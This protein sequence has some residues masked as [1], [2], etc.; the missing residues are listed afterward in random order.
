MSE[1]KNNEITRVFNLLPSS[2]SS[3]D[4]YYSNIMQLKTNIPKRYSLEQYCGPIKDQ[5]DAGF[6]HSFAGSSL[7]DIQ[8]NIETGFKYELSP[9]FLAKQVKSIDN[10]PSTE[11]AQLIYVCKA[12]QQ[13]GIIKEAYYPYSQYISGSLQFPELKYTKVPKYKI[14][15]YARCDT[16]D[17]MKQALSENK[18]ILLGITCCGNIRDLNNNADKFVP[19]PQGFFLG[20][21][22]LVIVGYDDD[23]THTYK[24]GRTCKGFFRIQNSW[25]TDWGDQGFAWLPYDYLTYKAHVIDENYITFFTEAWTMIDLIND[26]IKTT[27][28]KMTIG[29]PRVSID[30]KIVVWDQAPK[31]DQKTNRTLVPLRNL[32]ETLDFVVEWDG[33]KGLIT[34]TKE[35]E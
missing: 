19:L 8:E 16:I 7:K 30:N 9:L 3:K 33:E 13:E 32:A 23:L 21:H 26:K 27:T 11:G 1:T 14:Q 5:K 25:G 31:I 18:P 24:D 17:S 15:N 28:I 12:L 2:V 34:I 29:D 4:W 35:L 22:A 20:G 6:C 10:L